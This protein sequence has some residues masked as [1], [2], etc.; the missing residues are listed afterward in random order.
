MKE[1]HTLIMSNLEHARSIILQA[2][3]DVGKQLPKRRMLFFDAPHGMGVHFVPRLLILISGSSV[4][5][6]YCDGKTEWHR[7]QAP[8]IFYCAKKGMLFSEQRPTAEAVVLSFSYY[9]DHLRAMLCNYDG[10][11]KPPTERDCFMHADPLPEA[12]FKLIELIDNLHEE[13]CDDLI[14]PLLEV[15]F[16]LSVKQ[17]AMPKRLGAPNNKRMSGLWCEINTYL[18]IHRAEPITR[19]QLAKVF[20]VSQG[21]ISRLCR[22]FGGTALSQLMLEYRLE[23]AAALLLTTHMTVAEIAYASGFQYP[24]YFIDRFKRR[25]HQTPA[26]YRYNHP[27]GKTP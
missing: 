7:I 20:K 8:T 10:I 5:Q 6:Y 14:E 15:L 18:R 4:I 25:Y 11:R 1:N 2:C 23:H 19:A 12:G 26:D 24:S 22:R 9:P 13:Q 17:I 21:Y 16:R 27:E 3:N